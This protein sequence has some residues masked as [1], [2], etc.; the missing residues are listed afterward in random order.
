MQ[1]ENILLNDTVQKSLI[2]VLCF[3][4]GSLVPHFLAVGR[5]Y[6]KDRVQVKTS[7]NFY[8]ERNDE[9]SRNL[10]SVRVKIV[11]TGKRPIILNGLIF[12]HEDG[13]THGRGLGGSN[14]V[15]LNENGMWEDYIEFDSTSLL[16]CPINDT[17]AVNAWFCDTQDRK[18]YIKDV[19]INLKKFWQREQAEY[20]LSRI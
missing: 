19:K 3:L 16:Y 2:G 13:S 15:T 14:G 20:Q 5:E 4:C 7:S 9:M 10:R 8:K 11:N 1:L 18:Y 12:E 6:Y 17:G